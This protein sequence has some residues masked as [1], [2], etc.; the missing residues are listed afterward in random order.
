MNPLIPGVWDLIWSMVWIA[1]LILAVVA[2]LTLLRT[3]AAL[4][5]AATTL[6][7][8]GI[9]VI[10]FIGAFVWLRSSR[11]LR[12]T[13]ALRRKSTASAETAR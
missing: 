6:W 2:L 9:I 3:R 10:P 8:L 5:A 7:A 11:R 13:E 12:R 1:G 4:G